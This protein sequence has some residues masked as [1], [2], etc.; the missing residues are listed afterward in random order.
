MLIESLQ[1]KSVPDDG[2]DDLNVGVDG[3]DAV[4]DTGLEVDFPRIINIGEDEADGLVER[5]A[6]QQVPPKVEY[7]LTALG[8]SLM[9]VLDQLCTWGEEHMG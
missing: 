3:F 7:S 9:T 4:G 6:Y 1:G 8:D 2:V 5:H